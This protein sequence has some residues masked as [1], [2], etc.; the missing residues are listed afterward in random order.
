MRPTLQVYHNCINDAQET[1]KTTPG[2]KDSQKMKYKAGSNK[3][4]DEFDF[5]L[6]RLKSRDS[7]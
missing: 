7:K 3:C 5:V 1:A 4:K 2:G 6:D